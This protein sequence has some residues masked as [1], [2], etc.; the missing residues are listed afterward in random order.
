MRY[1]KMEIVI[2]TIRLAG[3]CACSSMRSRWTR[4]SYSSSHFKLATLVLHFGEA[5][6]PHRT[7]SPHHV[8][9]EPHAKQTDTE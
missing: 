9:R 1:G 5:S 8:S 7:T 6:W 4:Y 3:I 2:L